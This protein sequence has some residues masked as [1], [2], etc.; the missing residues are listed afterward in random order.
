[1]ATSSTRS[2]SPH[3]LPLA[4]EPAL[5]VRVMSSVR[6]LI[7]RLPIF[8]TDTNIPAAAAMLESWIHNLKPRLRLCLFPY[9]TTMRQT[10][11]R[12]SGFLMATR[13]LHPNQVGETL[14]RLASLPSVATLSGTRLI[15]IE[16]AE[17]ISPL[18]FVRIQ[19]SS[20]FLAYRRVL[21]LVSLTHAV[22]AIV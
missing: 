3:G 10:L 4:E 21:L 7:L 8:P 1:M 5:S 22:L 13:V 19:L 16:V 12:P 15:P 17:H 11:S 2:V 14:L 9:M 18:S 20:T 6:W